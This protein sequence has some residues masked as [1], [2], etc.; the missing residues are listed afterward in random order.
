MANTFYGGIKTKSCLKYKLPSELDIKKMPSPLYLAV[1]LS[2]KGMKTAEPLVAEGDAVDMGQLIASSLQKRPIESMADANGICNAQN[3]DSDTFGKEGVIDA[4]GAIDRENAIGKNNDIEN[5]KDQIDDAENDASDE[6]R[7]FAPVSGTVVG[8]CKKKLFDRSISDCIIIKNDLEFR[9]SKDLSPVTEPISKLSRRDILRRIKGAGIPLKHGTAFPS[10]DELFYY[11]NSD[12]KAQEVSKIKQ[13][14]IDCTECEPYIYSNHAAIVAEPSY[15]IGGIKILMA[16]F[17]VRNATLAVTSESYDYYDVYAKL[18]SLPEAKSPFE[19]KIMPHKK[20]LFS[21]VK[22]KA[23]YPLSNERLMIYSIAARELSKDMSSTSNGYIVV[24]AGICRAIYLAFAKGLPYT[25]RIV[26]VSGDCIKHPSNIIAPIGASLDDII[27]VCGGLT[28]SPERLICSGL[29]GGIA[30]NDTD[31]PVTQGV[32]SVMALS[33]SLSTRSIQK[34]GGHISIAAAS[35]S[36]IECG[37]CV[38]VCPMHLMPFMIA[39]YSEK[40]IYEKC[41]PYSVSECIDC[42]CCEYICP[43]ELPLRR[44]IKAAKGF[45]RSAYNSKDSTKGAVDTAGAIDTDEN[46]E[47]L[48]EIGTDDR[49]V[50]DTNGGDIASRKDEDISLIAPQISRAKKESKIAKKGAISGGRSKK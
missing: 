30:V 13:L 35:H 37:K 29:L 20:N 17:G 47:P 31:I 26:T 46:T 39:K 34:A 16:L 48:I 32:T 12:G 41:K 38:S 42:G 43:A 44:Y 45:M 19:A 5:L 25:E 11:T 14:I 50:N 9:R 1:P 10:Y 24:N 40:Q 6:S 27:S 23:K 28:R 4:D 8:Y 21:V 7:I 15:V 18:R 33:K 49:A 2:A 3:S 36:C 22:L